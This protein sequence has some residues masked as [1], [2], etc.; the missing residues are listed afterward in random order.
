MYCGKGEGGTYLLSSST[1]T[2]MECTSRS[3]L[4]SVSVSERVSELSTWPGHRQT[5]RQACAC[6]HDF[7]NQSQA[8]CQSPA[9]L[10]Q[11]TCRTLGSTLAHTRSHPC[12]LQTCPPPTPDYGPDPP[13]TVGLC[14]RDP[15]LAYSGTLPHSPAPRWKASTCAR[16]A[17]AC[18][19][20]PPRK[21]LCSRICCFVGGRKTSPGCLPPSLGAPCLPLPVSFQQSYCA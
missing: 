20:L 14:T 5:D 12:S 6:H 15:S 8:G 18:V 7:Q 3:T 13:Q 11:K 2:P 10:L 21:V 4:F 1:W 9:S 17:L 19:L 16:G